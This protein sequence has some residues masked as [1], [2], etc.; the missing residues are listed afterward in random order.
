MIVI[1]KINAD[2]AVESMRLNVPASLLGR[3]S[4]ERQAMDQERITIPKCRSQFSC[5]T[6]KVTGTDQTTPLIS[7]ISSTQRS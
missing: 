1:S 3:R 2:L 7:R 6:A 4:I 5:A